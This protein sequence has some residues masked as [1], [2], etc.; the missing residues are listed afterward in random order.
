MCVA[1]A[2]LLSLYLRV[3][4]PWH[5][6]FAPWGVDF[7]E[8]D[9]W[10]H[11]R[12]AHNLLAHF[13]FRSGFDPYAL[14]PGGMNMPTGPLWDYMI[15]STAWF[16]GLGSPSPVLTDHVAAWLPAILGALCPIPVFLAARRLFG[17]TAG[18]LAALCIASTH[19]EFLW[20]THLGNADHHAAEGFFALLVFCFLCAAADRKTSRWLPVLAGVSLGALLAAQ[21]AAIFVPG[22]LV[23]AVMLSPSLAPAVVWTFA[24]ASVVMLPVTIGLYTRYDWLALAAGAGAAGAVWALDI[25]HRRRGWP[26][27]A[28]WIAA[29]LALVL[30]LGIVEAVE[31]RLIPSFLAEIGTLNQSTVS[32]LQPV[33]TVRSL[34]AGFRDAVFHLGWSWIPALPALAGIC[35]LALRRRRPPLTLLAVFS[36]AFTAAAFLHL[37]MILYW[38]PFAAILAGAACAC[39]TRL[40]PHL[41]QRLLLDAGLTVVLLGFSVPPAIERMSST[42]SGA[43]RDWFAALTWLRVHSPEPFADTA[44][45][46]AYVPRQEESGRSSLPAPSYGIGLMWDTGYMVEDLSRR[47]PLSNGFGAGV[48]EQG[49]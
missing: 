39:L 24:A 26:S 41:R 43:G 31:P 32:E 9:A 49:G 4:P 21:P 15:A 18:V 40:L 42:I 23:G 44:L 16:A 33:V 20:L 7:Q 48:Q 1:C 36:L 35:I 6:V 25:L 29:A 30:V 27:W 38:A 34:R 19:G 2:V 17:L 47:V 28:R 3:V 37:R 22:L 12:T 14:F 45:W 46:N 13:P 8:T 5:I 11:L 10:F